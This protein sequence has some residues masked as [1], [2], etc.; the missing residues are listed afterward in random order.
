[1][2]AENNG[3]TELKMD[4]TVKIV[5]SVLVLSVG[6]FFVYSKIAGWHQ[7]KLKT[8][9]KQQRVISQR[10]ADQLE[11]KVAEL[12]QELD[13]VKGQK[14]PEEKSGQKLIWSNE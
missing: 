4:R 7:N 2:P 5:V 3:G 12:E 9:V 13:V 10:K 11:Q 1:M 8:A 14:V 6:G